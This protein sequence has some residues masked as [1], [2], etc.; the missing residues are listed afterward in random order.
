MRILI[1]AKQE[2]TYYQ[3]IDVNQ[4]EFELLNTSDFNDEFDFGDIEHDI[5]S[6]KLDLQSIYEDGAFTDF[7]LVK[8]I[9]K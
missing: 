1:K 7:E 5:L 4:G 3:E 6:T 8:L 9:A 2:V